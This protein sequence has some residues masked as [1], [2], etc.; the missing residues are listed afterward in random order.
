[1]IKERVCV[2]CKKLLNTSELIK[3]TYCKDK[4][5][6]HMQPNSK[7]TGRSAYICY[8]KTCIEQSIKKGRLQKAL[9]QKVNSKIIEI[10]QRL[11]K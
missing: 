11:A 3:I 7:I 2:S 4:N 6:T 9:K 1:M 5:T 10:L 8:N